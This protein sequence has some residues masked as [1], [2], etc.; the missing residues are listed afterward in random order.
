L[1]PGNGGRATRQI[2]NEEDILPGLRALGFEILQFEDYTFQEKIAY[3]QKSKIIISSNGSALT[4]SLFANKAATIIEISPA[5]T[6]Q[7]DHYKIICD[8][9]SIPFY[10]FSDVSVIN[11]PPTVGNSGWNM[12][13]NADSFFKCLALRI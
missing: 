9:L 4:F 13:I 10:R 2:L 1:N 6:T 12:N 7:M 3:F 8:T 5:N 11:G